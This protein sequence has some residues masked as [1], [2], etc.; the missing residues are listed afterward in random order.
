MVPTEKPIQINFTTKRI[1]D[2]LREKYEIS[3]EKGKKKLERYEYICKVYARE[4]EFFNEGTEDLDAYMDVC[5]KVE[6][7]NLEDKMI[8]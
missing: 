3:Y 8:D 7:V 2:Y 6:D 4:G 1:F 5:K